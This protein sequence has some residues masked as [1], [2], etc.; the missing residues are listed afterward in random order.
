VADIPFDLQHHRYLHY[1]NNA[2]GRAILE[3]GLAARFRSLQ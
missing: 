3:Q 1:L 2:E